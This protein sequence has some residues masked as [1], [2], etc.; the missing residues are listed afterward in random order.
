[1]GLSLSLLCAVN[2]A[3]YG[4]KLKSDEI[5]YYYNKLPAVQVDKNIKNYQSNIVAAYEAKNQQLI[6]EY[7]Q[8]K[9]A[10]EL[11]YEKEMMAY[12]AL[13][14]AADDRFDK[15]TAE[16]NKKSLGSKLLDNN[17]PVRQIPDK[18]NLAYVEKPVLQASYDYKT[19]ADTYINLQGYQNS[20]GNALKI[21]VTMYGYD[22]TV[23]RTMD[24]Q[25]SNV[26]LGGGPAKTYTSTQY[27]TEFSYRNPMTVKVYTPDGKE[28]LSLTPAELNSYKIYKSNATDRGTSI[29]SDLLIKTSQE[30]VLQENLR[31]INNMLN[32]RFGYSSI[33]R[34]ATLY[35]IKSDDAAYQDLTTAFN[36]ASSGLL[37]L[38]Q[39]AIGGK[40]KLDKACALWTTALTE[41]DLTN[42]KARINKE[43]A[44]AL[45]FNLLE[46]S[47]AAG[48][49][50]GGQAALDKINNFSLSSS[51]RRTKLDYD[52]LFTELK[53]RQQTNN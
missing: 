35:Y 47:F 30:R 29:N 51:E 17:K 1:M 50:A 37:M 23:P 24:E 28:M 39:D 5:V 14:K 49:V 18:P 22:H 46:A 31:F 34:T 32:D 19:L 44:I 10:A 20:P 52:M 6:A 7:E 27:H 26:S 2:M 45:Y 9:R 4:Q 38:Q 41:T 16:Y 11:K 53:T 48:N 25:Q 33:K 12:P 15:Q 43:V 13:V 36:E 40:N 42:K 3:C 21:V 8:N